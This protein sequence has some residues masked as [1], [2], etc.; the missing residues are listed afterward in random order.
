MPFTYRP[1]HLAQLAASLPG[2]RVLSGGAAPIDA[3]SQDSRQARPG[4]LFVA[5]KGL[6]VD[7][8][9]YAAAA[10]LRGAAVAVERVLDLPGTVPQ[11]LLPDTRWALGE[12]AAELLGRPAR[13]LKVVGVTGTDGKTTVT[14]LTA[15][16]LSACEMPTGYLSTVAQARPVGEVDNLSGKTTLEAPQVQEA[17]Q[18]MLRGG[19]TAAVLE[20]SSHALI[21]GRVS[22]CDFDAVA[23][24]NVG[25]DH[26][27]YHRTWEDY[28]KAKGRLIELCAAAPGKGVAKTAVLNLDDAASLPYLSSLRIERRLTC[29]IDGAADLSASELRPQPAGTGFRLSCD[30]RETGVL[31]PMVGRFNVANALTAAALCRALTGADAEALGAGLASFPG[32]PGRLEQVLLGQ[33]FAVYIDYA[34]AAGSLAQVLAELR[35]LTSGRILL[36]FGS[37]G[38]S[39]HDRPG[40]GRAAALGADWFVITTDD[41]VGEDP[42]EIAR[43]VDAGVTGRRRGSDY[44]LEPDRQVAVRRALSL[45]RPGD[46]V[47]LA[48]KGHEQ[49]MITAEGALPWSDRAAAQEALREL[50][51]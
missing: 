18:E 45:A 23:V 37:T 11:L 26:L 15:H 17:L 50:G 8:H 39:D 7:G 12:L 40:M 33:P 14:H 9:D 48:G 32:V 21:Q 42:V 4:A 19:Q 2:A 3:V 49:T 13:R 38:R 27:E 24:T 20:V 35:R 51:Y 41:P 46:A 34:H 31:L 22:G 36:V 29:A 44:E 30:G 10:A 1:M 6:H 28:L 16:L 47:L 5:I 25:H 43:Q